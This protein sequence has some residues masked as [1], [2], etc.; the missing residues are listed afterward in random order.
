LY[1]LQRR[2]QQGFTSLAVSILPILHDRT[3]REDAREPFAPDADGHYDFGAPA[4]RTS[5]TPSG[6]PLWPVSTASR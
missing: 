3:V 1:Y 6:S 2:R 5:P 4:L